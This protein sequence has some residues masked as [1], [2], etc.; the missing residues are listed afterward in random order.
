MPMLMPCASRSGL[1]FCGRVADLYGRKFCYLGGLVVFFIFNILSAVVKVRARVHTV[2]SQAHTYQPQV[3]LFV[4]RAFA[5]LGLALACPAGFGLIGETI[6]HEPERSMVFAAF[7]L[8]GPIGASSGT[9][10]GGGVAGIN[11][12]VAFPPGSCTNTVHRIDCRS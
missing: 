12:S 3:G 4:M 6:T 5:G 2:L 11:Q 1:L 7:G 9:I 10:L 8:G